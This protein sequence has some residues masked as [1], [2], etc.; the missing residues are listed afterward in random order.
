MKPEA[1][2]VE[3]EGQMHEIY[4]SPSICSTIY[5]LSSFYLNKS[6]RVCALCVCVV[7]VLTCV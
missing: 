7:Y 5:I 2:C 6:V 4:A 3:W 1:V